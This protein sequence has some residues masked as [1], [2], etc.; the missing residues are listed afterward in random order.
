[1]VEMIGN[2]GDDEN[3]RDYRV[4]RGGDDRDDRVDGGGDGNFFFILFLILYCFW[5]SMFLELDFL[6]IIIFFWGLDRVF[7]Y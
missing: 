2:G 1:M 7:L 5:M 4:D 3:G 6:I